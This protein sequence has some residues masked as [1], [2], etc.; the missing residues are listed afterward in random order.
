MLSFP[1]HNCCELKTYWEAVFLVHIVNI[2]GDWTITQS[3]L[4][5]NGEGVWL[6][7]RRFQVRV[8]AGSFSSL[9]KG[10]VP[11]Q[12][13]EST[14]LLKVGKAPGNVQEIDI[15]YEDYLREVE[16]ISIQT[17]HK[18]PTVDGKKPNGPWNLS[19][20]KV[21]RLELLRSHSACF[22][23]RR[24]TWKACFIISAL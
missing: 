23:K 7:I 8:L 19:M 5:P 6:R 10:L 2:R 11:L 13:C 18:G 15:L 3:A 4:W 16:D 20:L 17:W 1:V 14:C 24:V 12:Y 9:E 22:L 21:Q